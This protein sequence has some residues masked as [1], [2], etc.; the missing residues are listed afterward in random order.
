M[1]LVVN[2]HAG[3]C[4]YAWW[5]PQSSKLLGLA[6]TAG[7]VGSIPM[8]FRHFSSRARTK[9]IFGVENRDG[10]RAGSPYLDD[11]FQARTAPPLAVCEISSSH[12][13]A[14]VVRLALA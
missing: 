4:Q 11:L 10:Q 9:S 8:H 7:P 13:S 2:S 1:R 3:K 12:H 6:L 5:R 14:R